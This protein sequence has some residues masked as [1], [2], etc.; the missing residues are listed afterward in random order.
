MD[1]HLWIFIVYGYPLRN[2]LARISVIRY[3]CG[4]PRL[5]G[6]LKTG[7]Q[8]SWVSM[9]I[10]VDF[11]KSMNGFA[12]DSR[13]RDAQILSY[14]GDVKGLKD[15]MQSYHELNSMDHHILKWE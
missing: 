10:S 1:I 3:P 6:Y 14:L 13:T 15:R 8:K 9:L 5:Y 7:I 12:M 4:Y 2:V 11:W